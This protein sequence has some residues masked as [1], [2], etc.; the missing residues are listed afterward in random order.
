M[1]I[2]T[3][4]VAT[5]IINAF[6]DLLDE[7]DISIPDEDRTGD[8]GEARI[9]GITFAELL[10]KVECMVIELMEEECMNY[11][12]A[13]EWIDFNTIRSLAYAGETAPVIV[14]LV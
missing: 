8:E 14:D 6:E 1:K 5:D 7:H 13:C 4:E 10:G 2:Y 12:E 3:Q 9:Y 11:E